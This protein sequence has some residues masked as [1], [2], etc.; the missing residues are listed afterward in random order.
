VQQ[1]YGHEEMNPSGFPA[2]MVTAGD[3]QGEFS[4]NVQNSRVYAFKIEIFVPISQDPPSGI[5]ID[6]LEYAE[7]VV[8]TVID[9]MINV[10]DTDFML[11]GSDVTVL[12]VNAADV[13]WAYTD[14]ESGATRSAQLTLSVYTEKTIR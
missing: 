14:L 7:Q 1:V 11:T 3:M 8:A 12:F 2:V 10:F 6:R 9:E 4:S 5:T 13:Q